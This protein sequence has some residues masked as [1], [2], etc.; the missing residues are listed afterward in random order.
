VVNAIHAYLGWLLIS[1]I[2]DL[3]MDDYMKHEMALKRSRQMSL[4]KLILLS[5]GVLF[6]VMSL[7]NI[8]SLHNAEVTQFPD[9][10]SRILCTILGLLYLTGALGVHRR[11]EI[12]WR[13]GILIIVLN[14]VLTLVLI[15]PAIYKEA[16][17]L[18]FE[19]F[20]LPVCL[21]VLGFG[22]VSFYWALWWQRQRDY[23][24]APSV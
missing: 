10:Y 19:S 22:G 11:A 8:Q 13:L 5:F 23:F 15:I 1:F 18:D 3:V 21:S 20:W 2:G 6:L 9:A 4:L 16:S 17:A 12:V 7:A 24:K 14:Y